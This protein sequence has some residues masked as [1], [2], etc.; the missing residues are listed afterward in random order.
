MSS[1]GQEQ[2]G[3]CYAPKR[4]DMLPGSSH[5]FAPGGWFVDSL[6]RGSFVTT[7]FEQDA[8]VGRFV[9]RALWHGDRSMLTFPSSTM[10]VVSYVSDVPSTTTRTRVDVRPSEGETSTRSLGNVRFVSEPTDQMWGEPS[11]RIQ[12]KVSNPCGTKE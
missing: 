12:C 5:R 11:P 8:H 4:R 9:A 1:Q 3:Y 6:F 7:E 10:V 2:N